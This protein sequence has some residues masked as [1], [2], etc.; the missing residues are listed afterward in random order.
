MNTKSLVTVYASNGEKISGIYMGTPDDFQRTFQQYKM[1]PK[2][3]EFGI[4]LKKE[5]GGFIRVPVEILNYS[6]VSVSPIK[7]EE[8]MAD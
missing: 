3:K 2:S 7:M 5:D 8:P 4:N 6:L 1:H